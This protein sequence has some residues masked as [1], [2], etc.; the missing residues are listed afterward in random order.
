MS[1]T[2]TAKVEQHHLVL[3]IHDPMELE[4]EPFD[5]LVHIPLGEC[6]TNLKRRASNTKELR[7]E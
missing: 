3:H 5:A 6:R 2:L 4:A 1:Y 7:T